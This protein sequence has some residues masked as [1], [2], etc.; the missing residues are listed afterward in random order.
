MTLWLKNPCMYELDPSAIPPR[1]PPTVKLSPSGK[2]GTILFL[3]IVFR[4]TLPTVT[5]A[6]QSMYSFSTF[7]I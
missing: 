2:E 4:F 3:G 7:N 1:H 5:V 6:S